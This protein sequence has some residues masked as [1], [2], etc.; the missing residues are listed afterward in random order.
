MIKLTNLTF[1]CLA[2]AL[3]LAQLPAQMGGGDPST[4]IKE[5]AEAIDKQLKEID[6]L[7]LESGRKGQSRK[8]P[9]ELLEQAA[10]GSE[11]VQDGIDK[12]IEKLN[13]MKNQGGGGGGGGGESDQQKP[14]DP[15]DGQQQ[16]K[17]G[18]Q[19]QSGE[20]RREN[21]T[22]DF[23]QQP[24]EGEQP[25][26]GQKPQPQ[27]GQNQPGQQQPKPG[28][29]DPKGGQETKDGGENRTG[30]APPNGAT[31]KGQPGTGEG[32]WGNL[33]PYLNF[34]RNRGASPKVPEKYRKYYEAYL[35]NKSKG[36]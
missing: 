17:P 1:W 18:Q 11:I 10:E 36:K 12:L 3:P 15:Q 23:V 9:K 4:E 30:K 28:E 5:I 32:G 21:Q 33:Q 26:E 8:K 20:Q 19:G 24:K 6:E 13:D 29:G 34:L 27:P 16:P 35:K 2:L 7:L 25:G 22:P 31:G 14:G